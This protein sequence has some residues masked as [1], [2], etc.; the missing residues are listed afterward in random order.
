MHRTPTTILFVVALAVAGCPRVSSSPSGGSTRVTSGAPE[1][2]LSERLCERDRD[3]VLTTF[4]GCCACCECGPPRAVSK[5]SVGESRASCE[6]IA[7]QPC[8]PDV[9]CAPC[10]DPEEGGLRARCIRGDCVAVEVTR[11]R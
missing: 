11:K 9:T 7:C 6:G 1:R 3:C 8:D 2:S 4:P 5:G 10:V